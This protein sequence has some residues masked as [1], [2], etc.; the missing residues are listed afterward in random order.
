MIRAA[1]EGDK[2]LPQETGS[3]PGRPSDG[4]NL[5]KAGDVCLIFSLLINDFPAFQPIKRT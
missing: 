1:T 5:R 4:L 3:S 2:C